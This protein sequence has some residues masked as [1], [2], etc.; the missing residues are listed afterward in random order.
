M[1]ANDLIALIG[2]AGTIVGIIVAIIASHRTTSDK[3]QKGDEALHD[4]INRV[5]DEYVKRADLDSH[6]ARIEANVKELR[7]ENREG[8]REI[9][10]RLDQVLTTLRPGTGPARRA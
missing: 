3:I 7:E 2:L 5:R 9:N 4:R 1:S 8:T 10:R 6:M